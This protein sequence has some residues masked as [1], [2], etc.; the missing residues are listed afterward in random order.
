MLQ[1]SA[2]TAGNTAAGNSASVGGPPIPLWETCLQ[3][4]GTLLRFPDM[5]GRAHGV[6]FIRHRRQKKKK[7]IFPM[8]AYAIHARWPRIGGHLA[9]RVITLRARIGCSVANFHL[10]AIS[11]K[12]SYSVATDHKQ[13]SVGG[14]TGRCLYNVARSGTLRM[15]RVGQETLN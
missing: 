8:E 14:L 11:G 9:I 6:S 15:H 2:S 5:L 13:G 4:I 10:Q 1:A 7:R 12:V 3:S